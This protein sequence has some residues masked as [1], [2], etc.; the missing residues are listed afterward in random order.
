[1]AASSGSSPLSTSS[2][3]FS[4][5]GYMNHVRRVPVQGS[6]FKVQGLELKPTALNPKQNTLNLEL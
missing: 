3:S 1:V 4:L 2:A 5:V 6:E